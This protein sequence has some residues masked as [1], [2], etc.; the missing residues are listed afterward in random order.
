MRALLTPS[1][2]DIAAANTVPVAI[3]GGLLVNESGL[4]PA[5]VGVNGED[6]GVA[7]INLAAHGKNVSLAEAMDPHYAIHWSAEEL[8]MTYSTWKSK[9]ADGVDPWDIAI[10]NHNSPKL[11]M[12]WAKSGRPPFVEGRVFQ[13]IEYVQKVRTSW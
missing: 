5:A 1:I 7:Q 11:A 2:T 3:L 12:Q 13:I 8:W 10:A 9:A 6:H 4:D